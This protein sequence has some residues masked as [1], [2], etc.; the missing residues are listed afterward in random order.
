MGIVG[1]T[2]WRVFR[3]IFLEIRREVVHGDGNV[4]WSA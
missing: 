4:R 2:R 3:K 1:A